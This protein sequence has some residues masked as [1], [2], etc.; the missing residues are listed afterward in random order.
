MMNAWRGGLNWQRSGNIFFVGL[1]SWKAMHWPLYVLLCSCR[2]DVLAGAL[3]SIN[4]VNTSVFFF[5]FICGLP[6]LV[7]TL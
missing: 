7:D 5:L 1:H 4:T 3:L 2:S 6:S